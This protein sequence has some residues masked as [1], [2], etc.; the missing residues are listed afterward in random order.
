MERATRQ[1]SAIAHFVE[2]LDGF[3]S[4]QQIHALLAAE[5]I[6]VGLATVYRTLAA[7]ASDGD[8][9][10]VQQPDGQ[11]L[12]RRCSSEHHHHLRCRS[13]G[14]TVEVTLDEHWADALAAEHGFSEISHSLEL[15]GLCAD[16]R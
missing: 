15:V 16:C 12:Y 10:Q 11:M 9:D 7:L 4:A 2:S 6:K 1:R 13:C 8:L 5:G 14:K 3:H